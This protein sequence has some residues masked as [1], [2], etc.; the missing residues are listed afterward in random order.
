MSI[1]THHRHLRTR[2]YKHLQQYPHP[3][4]LIRALDRLVFVAGLIGP[5]MTLPQIYTIYVLGDVTGVSALTWSAYAILDIP[6]II[7]GLIHRESIIV[8]AY[9]LWL[10]VNGAVALGVLFR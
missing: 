2:I 8:F 4:A 6:W 1:G 7:Y 3:N 9:T 10:V 5:I